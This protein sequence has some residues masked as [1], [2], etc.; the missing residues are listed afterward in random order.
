MKGLPVKPRAVTEPPP[1][2]DLMSALK[3]SLAQEK[4]AKGG[5]R[6]NKQEK[7]TKARLD[8]RQ[9]SLLLPVSGGRRR[10]E[11]PAAEQSTTG[12][13]RRKKA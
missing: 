6:A 12:T 4:P 9:P 11:Q 5:G 10:R 1:V 2:I 7:R 13:R 8:R 3:R